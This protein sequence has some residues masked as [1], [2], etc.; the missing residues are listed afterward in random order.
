MKVNQS[1]PRQTVFHTHVTPTVEEG[2]IGVGTFVTSDKAPQ[3]RHIGT[4]SHDPRPSGF[5]TDAQRCSPNWGQE[6][7]HGDE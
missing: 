2:A 7:C 5:L 1:G 4:Q 6:M 3:Y